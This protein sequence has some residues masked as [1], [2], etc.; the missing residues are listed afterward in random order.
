MKRKTLFKNAVISAAALITV[1]AVIYSCKKN[2][3]NENPGLAGASF[4][5]EMKSVTPTAME[6]SAHQ[7]EL[8]FKRDK[9]SNGAIPTAFELNMPGGKNYQVAVTSKSKGFGGVDIYVGTVKDDLAKGPASKMRNFTLVDD[10]KNN[11][12]FADFSIDKVNYTLSKK[13]DNTFRLSA[14]KPVEKNEKDAIPASRSAKQAAT[15]L[16]VAAGEQ[17]N[18]IYII[19][20]FVGYSNQAVA[21]IG[22]GNLIA[23][24]NDMVASVNNG[25][26]NSQVDNV[27]VRLVG[28]GTNP[29]NP[30]VVPQAL[31]DG[32]T[33][34]AS[35]LAST[36]ADL[37]CLVQQP[38]NAPGSAGG[39]GNMPGWVAVAGANWTTVYRHEIGHNLGSNHCEPGIRPYAAGY[40]NG[41]W[42]TH[43]CNNSVNYYS[44]PDVL[45]D[46][47][48]PLG[49]ANT[50]NNAR[51][52]RERAAEMSGRVAHILPFTDCTSTQ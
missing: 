3:Q 1:S 37:L 35:G 49:N 42:A 36:G 15:E 24:A 34:F 48:H 30:G 29:N 12:V 46:Q 28:T 22:A 26:A 16:A 13:E 39:Y 23:Y 27:R 51:L 52:W 4:F 25:L 40:D 19:D 2:V 9:S 14:I 47:G 32:P 18:G 43:M 5:T 17:C 44:N 10:P 8:G 20:L 11:A 41:H 45:D 31:D 6:I 50:A 7:V 33:W 21:S 38:T